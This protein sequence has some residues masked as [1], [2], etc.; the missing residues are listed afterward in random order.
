MTLGWP[1]ETGKYTEEK[2]FCPTETAIN[3]VNGDI[4]VADGYGSNWLTH[5]S[6]KGEVKGCYKHDGFNCI[7]GVAYDARDA[8]NPKLGAQLAVELKASA[9]QEIGYLVVLG[10]YLMVLMAEDAVAGQ[11]TGTA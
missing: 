1:K 2:Q 3:P 7:H 5:Y 10:W 8:A 4:Y 6:A 9:H 11:P